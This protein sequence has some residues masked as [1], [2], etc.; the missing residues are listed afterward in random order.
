[1]LL[2]SLKLT[3]F[4]NYNETELSFSE[5]FVTFTGANG[6]G[7]TNLLDA[8][9]YLC[10]GKSYFQSTELNNVIHGNTFFRLEGNLVVVEKNHKIVAT[11]QKG[12]QKK[13]SVDSVPYSRLSEH[14]GRFPVTMIAP[15]DSLLI[16]GSSENRRR[17]LDITLSQ[18]DK[19]YVHNLQAYNKLITQRN[20]HLKEQRVDA[21]LL[22]TYDKQLIEKALT[23]YGTR[24]Q[25]VND[26]K[27]RLKE[28]YATFS[29]H[30]EEFDC[31]YKSQVS[32]P[33]F[34]EHFSAARQK[35]IILGRTQFGIHRDDLRFTL[36]NTTVKNFGSQGQQKSVLLALKLLQHAF[37]KEI[38]KKAPILLL[39]DIFD[40]LDAKRINFLL[41]FLVKM[42][43]V[44]VFITHTHPKR[45]KEA[46]EKVNAPHEIFN[47]ANEIP[48]RSEEE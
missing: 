41:G 37:I 13:L 45:I 9:F 40:K 44:Q 36:D 33:N 17:F 15:N 22:D 30:A 42:E 25:F 39:D 32:D 48:S 16:T 24:N 1:L 38:A 3:N 34:K 6:V 2:K 11:Y 35:D 28:Y 12:K 21:T 10:F 31:Q 47:L 43:D 27:L 23:I 5:R 20:K 26:I 19:A 29:G 18:V 4:K 8:I 14:L 46:L 7:K